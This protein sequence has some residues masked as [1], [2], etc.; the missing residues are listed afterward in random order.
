VWWCWIWS[1]KILFIYLFILFCRYWGL[2]SGFH[3]C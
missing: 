1:H 3:T 2:N